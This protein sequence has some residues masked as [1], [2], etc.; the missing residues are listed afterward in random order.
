MAGLWQVTLKMQAPAATMD[1][2]I[3]S[4]CIDSN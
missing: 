3:Y 1:T 2:V 4:F